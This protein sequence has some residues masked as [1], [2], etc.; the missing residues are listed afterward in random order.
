MN[1]ELQTAS[2]WGASAAQSGAERVAIVAR[3]GAIEEYENTHPAP[4]TAW[5]VSPT[6]WLDM[7]QRAALIVHTH[8]SGRATPSRADLAGQIASAIPWAICPRGEAAFL[9]GVRNPSPLIGRGYRFGVDDCFSLF[10]DAFEDFSGT[11]IPNFPRA[12]GFWRR[13]EKLFESN[14]A[15]AGFRSVGRSI[16]VAE[17]G[18]AILFRIRSDQFNH[19]AFYQGGGW[20]LHH[21]APAQ[22]FDLTRLSVVERVDRWVGR[23]G[24]E[25]FRHVAP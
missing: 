7:L 8:P 11:R 18:D 5:R 6:D 10:R 23:L 2:E 4:A 15:A 14:I 13:E 3:S 12:W 22:P 19:A 24:F 1:R 17:K 25:V 21:A 16:E 20:M 9:I